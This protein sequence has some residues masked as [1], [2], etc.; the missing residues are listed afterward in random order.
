[1]LWIKGRIIYI[2]VSKIV[3]IKVRNELILNWLW[4]DSALGPTLSMLKANFSSGQFL[5]QSFH[6]N[7]NHERHFLSCLNSVS[8]HYELHSCYYS[9]NVP[10]QPVYLHQVLEYFLIWYFHLNYFYFEQ[11]NFKLKSRSQR[12]S[13]SFEHFHHGNFL[14]WI[15]SCSCWK[16]IHS[17][18]VW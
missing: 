14:K 16:F 5:C 7:G 12:V 11:N 9:V 2:N 4:S 1:M 13:I 15:V 18:L 10:T 17:S 6:L 8:T 3:M